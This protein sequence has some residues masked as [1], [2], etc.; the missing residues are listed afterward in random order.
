[1]GAVVFAVQL[2]NPEGRPNG[3]FLKLRMEQACA[4]ALWV[5][6]AAEAYN[7][8]QLTPADQRSA[9]I[10]AALVRFEFTVRCTLKDMILSPLIYECESLAFC[11]DLY[12]EDWRLWMFPNFWHQMAHKVRRLTN[13]SLYPRKFPILLIGF[14]ICTPGIV[15]LLSCLSLGAKC[16]CLM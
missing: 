13:Q 8:E 9:A 2:W 6:L 1:M 10:V 11:L 3:N 12:M 7:A 5:T 16:V 14:T 15:D 4:E